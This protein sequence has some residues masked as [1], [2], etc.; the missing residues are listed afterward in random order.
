V[1]AGVAKLVGTDRTTIVEEASKLLT[2]ANAY[3][4][5]SGVAN[6]YG[7]GKAAGRIVSILAGE[8]YEPFSP[9]P[10]APRSS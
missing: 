7:D 3:R 9:N 10:S 1:E 2:D 5:M 8:S 4:S 6:P